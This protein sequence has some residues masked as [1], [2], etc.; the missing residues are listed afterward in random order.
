[1]IW[2]KIVWATSTHLHAPR[3]PPLPRQPPLPGLPIRTWTAPRQRRTASKTLPNKIPASE[4]SPFLWNA[5][6]KRQSAGALSRAPRGRPFRPLPPVPLSSSATCLQNGGRM[7]GHLNNSKGFAPLSLL[8]TLLM[9]PKHLSLSLSLSL[10]PSKLH[11]KFLGFIFP[12]KRKPKLNPKINPKLAADAATR[13]RAS[14][15]NRAATRRCGNPRPRATRD[16]ATTCNRAAISTVRQPATV[17]Q[18]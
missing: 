11:L 8:S 2:I 5:A 1:M 15:H 13:D 7:E 9:N 4:R 6:G 16:R 18:G 3:L 10:S 14:T 12:K 17:W